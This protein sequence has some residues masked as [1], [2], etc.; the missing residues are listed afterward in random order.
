MKRKI[1]LSA[2]LIAAVMLYGCSTAAPEGKVSETVSSSSAASSES[3]VDAENEV[4][5]D[6]N[7]REET[8]TVSQYGE[9]IETLD[10]FF[11]MG[12]DSGM[13]ELF[14]TNFNTDEED[15]LYP[16]K[17]ATKNI[18]AWYDANGYVYYETP[19]ARAS[20]FV[21][22]RCVINGTSKVSGQKCFIL[23]MRN[24]KLDIDI[25]AG[26]TEDDGNNIIYY[27][28]DP[29]GYTLWTA[30][31][32]DTI[33]GSEVVLTAWDNDGNIKM[34]V[35][36]ADALNGDF[37]VN[38]WYNA[39]LAGDRNDSTLYSEL[40]HNSGPCYIFKVRN[41]AQSS[42]DDYLIWYCLNVEN[43]TVKQYYGQQD[44]WLSAYDDVILYSKRWYNDS[45]NYTVMNLD[46]APK[47]GG[48][49]FSKANYND[50]MLYLKGDGFAE[51]YYDSNENLVVDMSDDTVVSWCGF[52]DRDI[53]VMKLKNPEGVEFWR[54]LRRDGTWVNEAQKGSYEASIGTAFVVKTDTGRQVYDYNG[55]QRD[56][57]YGGIFVDSSLN[58]FKFFPVGKS[59][60]YIGTMDYQ[61]GDSYKTYV[62][63]LD[64]ELDYSY[65][66]R[67]RPY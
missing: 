9:P 22:G 13:A 35:S 20:D 44:S 37:D 65:L 16:I 5:S 39:L 11:S 58:S 38:S 66:G 12:K 49:G 54:L 4:T 67:F 24:G 36:T 19:I 23:T 14:N 45:R 25:P 61:D 8:E 57:L 6:V 21:G 30:R 53:G 55:T 52:D 43:G 60:K 26:I 1:A 34:Q 17:N 18:W 2:A 42:G 63:V 64:N 51:G 32:D 46:L 59:G 47:F 48:A 56:N 29:T 62:T 10:E 40:F 28:K 31:R 41:N 33:N 50:G 7:V 27:D 3:T 15:K